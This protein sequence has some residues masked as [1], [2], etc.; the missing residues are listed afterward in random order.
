MLTLSSPFSRH[1]Y[2]F[3]RLISSDNDD[4]VREALALITILFYDGNHNAQ[5]EFLRYVRALPDE[6]FFADI[7]NRMQDAMEAIIEVFLF[8]IDIMLITLLIAMKRK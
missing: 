6:T 2:V 7:D 4:V 8:N 5:K 1:K 3:I